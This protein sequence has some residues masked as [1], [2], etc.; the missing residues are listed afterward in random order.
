MKEKILNKIG[1][2]LIFFWIVSTLIQFN[3]KTY[4]ALFWIC[5]ISIAIL[6]I[7]CIEKNLSAI[8]FVVGTG[9]VFQT[10]WIAD[11]TIFAITQDSPIKLF[12][13]Y[14]GTPIYAFIVILIRHILTVPLG[15]GLI[16]F[17]NPKKPRVE[18][19]IYGILIVLAI[20]L[21]SYTF[22]ETNN[23]NCEVK[24]C[25]A[26]SL[27]ITGILYTLIWAALSIGIVYSTCMLLIYPAHLGINRLKQIYLNHKSQ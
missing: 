6:A 16:L 25:G 14:A 11:W 12:E 19:F 18:E 13:L 17:F 20:F 26:I 1:Y 9:L 27:E 4:S 7:A 24:T 2:F 22:G 21:I 8:Y 10:I 3:L 15:L 5:N 23:V